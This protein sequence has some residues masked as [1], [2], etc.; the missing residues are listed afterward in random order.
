[1]TQRWKITIEYDGGA[2]A[3]WQKQENGFAVQSA[4]EE[5]IFKFS[6]ERVDTIVAGRTDS[7]VHALGQVAH[8]DLEKDVDEKTVRDATNFHLRPHRVAIVSAE[9]VDADFN[10]RTS[11]LKRVYCYKM[12]SGRR[13][14][15]MIDHARVWNTGW[16]LDIDAMNRA[17]KHLIGVHDFSTFRAS[18]CQAK[19]P[20]RTLDRLE[21]IETK[22]PAHSFGRHIEIWA[23]ARSFLHH[24][25]RNIAGTLELVGEGKWTPDDVKNALEAKDRTKGG[26]MA[27]A[28][29]LYFVRVEYPHDTLLKA[30]DTLL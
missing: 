11:A 22:S 19:S 21:V 25:I 15:A 16:D 28:Y 26:P 30:I 9:K 14:D 17:A 3:G 10:A 2:F 23:E 7:G 29:G 18:E 20:V 5:A 27:P 8:F 13:A 1:M 4:V 12:L 24:Q 6:G